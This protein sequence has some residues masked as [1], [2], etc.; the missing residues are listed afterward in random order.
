MIKMRADCQP[1]DPF[2]GRV[3]F[4][5]VS[6]L[7]HARYRDVEDGWGTEGSR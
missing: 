5:M 7:V 6:S 3:M 4:T 1:G 2:E